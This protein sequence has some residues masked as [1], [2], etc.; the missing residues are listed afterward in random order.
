M[1]TIVARK[2]K[3]ASKPSGGGNKSLKIALGLGL[4]FVAILIFAFS[5]GGETEVATTIDDLNA[6]AGK[7]LASVV[8]DRVGSGEVLVLT[9]SGMGDVVDGLDAG[10]TEKGLTVR[11]VRAFRFSGD[12]ENANAGAVSSERLSFLT[13]AA[14]SG[15]KGLVLLGSCPAELGQIPALNGGAGPKVIVFGSF[16]LH[17][18]K[19]IQANIVQALLT[20]SRKGRQRSADETVDP[21][22]VVKSR[23]TLINPANVQAMMSEYELVG[24]Q[25]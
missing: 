8:A 23:Y 6:A 17:T 4:L 24:G 13:E 10:L 11:E 18:A 20:R 5:G 2:K 3:A 19:L 16:D 9:F 7:H 12:E 21:A 1:E 22:E 25:P 15:V 14:G